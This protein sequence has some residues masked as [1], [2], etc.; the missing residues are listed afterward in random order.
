[1]KVAAVLFWLV[2]ALSAEVTACSCLGRPAPC[3]AYWEASVIFAGTV[4]YSSQVSGKK[5]SY[6][7]SKRLVRFNVDEAF[8]GLDGTEAELFTGLGGG[9]CGYE[10][11]LGGQYLVYAYRQKDGSLY[12]GICSRTRPLSDA[13]DDLA[14]IRGLSSAQPGA[15]VFGQVQARSKTG[16]EPHAVKAAKIIIEG[17][18]KLAD[19]TTD[20]KGRYRVSGLPP[21]T[22]KVR[23][24]PPEGLSGYSSEREAKVVDRG[25]AQVDFWLEPDTR[26]T[27]KVVDANGLPAPDVL[28]ELVPDDVNRVGYAVFV[29]TDAD[30]K[31]AFPLVKPGRYWLGVRIYGSAGST[32]VPYPRT[33]YPGVAD[34]AQATIIDVKD[35]AKINLNELILPPRLVESVL[36][37]I[38]VDVNGR[39]V[40]GA[41]VWLKEREYND[42]D[43]PYRTESDNE[44]RF[45]FKVYQGINYNLN[46]YVD[47]SKGN[48]ELSSEPTDVR[49]DENPKPVR[50]VLHI[51]A[52]TN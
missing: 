28:M 22:Y 8:L 35:G 39:P 42:R 7:R 16:E 45:S 51:Q 50:L 13:A 9:D 12:T 3:E 47:D 40:K 26:I 6:E 43:M 32:Y 24:A 21:G 2:Y 25:C 29:K 52:P 46:A 17:P 49:V 48:R 1:M 44:G 30:G 19:A 41:T 5:G 23:I 20:E 34:E 11:K 33:Y 18:A 15:T 36:N 4:T 31:Y 27:G 10:F 37:G 14:Y 38:V